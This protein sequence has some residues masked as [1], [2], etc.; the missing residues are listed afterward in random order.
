MRDK[1]SRRGG[2]YAES[3]GWGHGAT[4]GCET[5][6]LAQQRPA[7]SPPFSPRAPPVAESEAKADEPPWLTAPP[8]PLPYLRMLDTAT[9]I[10]TD[11]CNYTAMS[12]NL[13]PS[14]TLQMLHEY[15]SKLDR[16]LDHVSQF[17]SNPPFKYQTVSLECALVELT[18]HV[19]MLRGPKLILA[20]APT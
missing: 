2:T 19:G 10:F 3:K 17:S 8:E 6:L 16:L 13:P 9:V 7:C 11:I 14:Q 20:R 5:R 1:G 18:S 15:F 4:S 12:S